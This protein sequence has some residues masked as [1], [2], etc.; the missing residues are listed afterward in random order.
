MKWS[1]SFLALLLIY[2]IFPPWIIQY[3]W[4][5]SFLISNESYGF[6]QILFIFIPLTFTILY[7]QTTY[8][9]TFNTLTLQTIKNCDFIA[10]DNNSCLSFASV[11]VSNDSIPSMRRCVVYLCLCYVLI[12]FVSGGWY[13]SCSDT[14]LLFTRH[15]FY[16]FKICN[17]FHIHEVII[18]KIVFS[19]E[20]VSI[21][22]KIISPLLVL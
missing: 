1:H 12:L 15:K 18:Y 8:C 7:L 10:L 22:K 9:S 20:C 2:C 16:C 14:R 3:I 17:N 21:R 6:I 13:S 11:M 19:L 4:D 5:I